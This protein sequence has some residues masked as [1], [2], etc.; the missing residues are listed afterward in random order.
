M[1]VSIITLFKNHAILLNTFILSFAYIVLFLALFNY[2][3]DEKVDLKLTASDILTTKLQNWNRINA[4]ICFN[5][6]QQQFIL[7]AS[8]MNALATGKKGAACKAVSCLLECTRGTQYELTL[9]D[10][11]LKDIGEVLTAEYPRADSEISESEMS[12]RDP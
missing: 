10:E 5:F 7:I 9:D 12:Q 6:L 4:V 8:T 1:A 2:L 11:C 3:F